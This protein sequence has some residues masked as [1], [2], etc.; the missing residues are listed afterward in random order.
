MIYIRFNLMISLWHACN[1][2]H[3]AIN[4]ISVSRCLDNW[5]FINRYQ[6]L[7]R[8]D[9]QRVRARA[10]G[11]INRNGVKWLIPKRNS[12]QT[13]HGLFS[14]MKLDDSDDKKLAIV[15]IDFRYRSSIS[16]S[17]ID[18]QSD[19]PRIPRSIAIVFAVTTIARRHHLS[20]RTG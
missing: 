10:A 11:V 2:N 7:P 8:E 9:A 20:R 16:A 15:P 5:F 4:T 12:D 18:S 3:R 19:L 1:I 6:F 17:P 13:I 14:W